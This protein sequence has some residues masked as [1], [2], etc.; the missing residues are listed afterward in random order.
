M[1]DTLLSENAIARPR[2]EII[3]L[4]RLRFYEES[5]DTDEAK[6]HQESR[7]EAQ[8]NKFKSKSGNHENET[9]HY[10]RITQ[11]MLI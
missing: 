6:H 9:K 11:E 8:E 2:N 7:N 1:K 4:E 10:Q 5:I 3:D